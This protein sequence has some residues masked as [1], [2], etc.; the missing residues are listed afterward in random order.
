[1]GTAAA[2]ASRVTAACKCKNCGFA[3]SKFRTED[4]EQEWRRGKKTRQWRDCCAGVW[5]RTRGLA[6][7]LAK[8]VRGR[9]FLRLISI[10][11]STRRKRRATNC[12]FRAARFAGNNLPRWRAQLKRPARSVQARRRKILRARGIGWWDR[13][14]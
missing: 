14:G 10:A 11:R 5:R 2:K 13:A 8:T 12:I 9:R 6:R 1:M 7:V 3:R 4:Q